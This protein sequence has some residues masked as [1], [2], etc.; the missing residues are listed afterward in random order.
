MET[1]DRAA[2]RQ[3]LR[4]KL[5]ER[6]DDRQTGPRGGGP[7]NTMQKVEEI[8]LQTLGDDAQLLQTATDT[9]RGVAKGKRSPKALP[10]AVVE[11]SDDEE[12]PPQP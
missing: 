8:M 7:E 5:R 9:L 3:R 1:E 11:Y 10:E 6:R 12:A 4:R 2:L